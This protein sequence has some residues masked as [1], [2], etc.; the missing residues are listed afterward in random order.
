[1]AVGYHNVAAIL[2]TKVA[3]GRIKV[4]STVYANNVIKIFKNETQFEANFRDSQGNFL[5]KG[6]EVQFEINGV[7]YIRK[8]FD[9]Q[10][11]AMLNIN[12]NPGSYYIVSTNLATQESVTNTI[13]ILSK[14]ADNNDLVK[15]YKNETQ[16]TVKILGNDGN[17]KM[18][19]TVKFTVHG[20]TYERTSDE[21]G[22]AKLNIKLEPGEYDI[23][24]E[25]GGN[26]AVNNITVK[27]IFEP[28]LNTYG[29]GVYTIKLLDGHGSPYTNQLVRF[30][31]NGVFYNVM[32][33][34]Y[35]FATLKLNLMKGTYIITA[36][37][38]GLCA[39]ETIIV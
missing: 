34:D 20:I 37:Y 10:G 28:Q 15:Y 8:I 12:L 11:K 39:S 21:N 22:I 27:S 14:I 9:D 25:Y 30:N 35:G 32:T 33:D 13:L 1:M 38:N 24:T 18:G 36:M 29:S 6:T 7:T 3:T 17:V 26:Y 4:L 31:I 19:E 2:L 16:F 23:L 5:P